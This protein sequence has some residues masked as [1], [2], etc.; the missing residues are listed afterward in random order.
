MTAVNDCNLTASSR[1]D[2]AGT[3][4]NMLLECGHI[5]AL[6]VSLFAFPLLSW[7]LFCRCLNHRQVRLLLVITVTALHDMVDRRLEVLKGSCRLIA[8]VESRAPDSKSMDG[9]KCPLKENTFT[10]T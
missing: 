1:T 8:W 5:V 3:L 9:Q 4:E 7:G 2:P 10:G 6:S